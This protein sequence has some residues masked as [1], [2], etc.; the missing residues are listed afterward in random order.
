[1]P[2]LRKREATIRAQLDALDAELVDHETY[3]KL[4]ENLDSFLARLREGIDTASAEDRQRVLRAVVRE[5]LVGT[6]RVVIRH[7][8]PFRPSPSTPDCHLRWG[9]R[10]AGTGEPVSALHARHLD[11]AELAAHPVRTLRR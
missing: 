1:M 9:S 10:L 8:I 6:D 7:S 4:A 2:E 5:V 11:A 3:L